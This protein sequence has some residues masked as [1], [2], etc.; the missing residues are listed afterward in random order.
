MSYC[1][2]GSGR[3]HVGVLAWGGE[4]LIPRLPFSL[5]PET[6]VHF[7]FCLAQ[8]AEKD[9]ECHRAFLFH[10]YFPVLCQESR[11][12]DGPGTS[13]EFCLAERRKEVCQRITSQ[14]QTACIPW[15]I[16]TAM[17][18]GEHSSHQKHKNVIYSK[19]STTPPWAMAKL[20]IG[21]S[22]QQSK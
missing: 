20:V 10:V 6:K 14:P 9:R 21:I 8:G 5:F 17:Q 11:T 2:D 19:H 16:C 12:L 3:K 18:D 15:P 1:Q 7:F 4:T 13:W 22:L